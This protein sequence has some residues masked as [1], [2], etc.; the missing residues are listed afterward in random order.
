MSKIAVLLV[1]IGSPE[2]PQ[3]KDVGQYLRRFLM[4]PRVIEL[5]FVW[6]W[7]LVNL[8]IVP[9]RS[10]A[11]ARKYQEIWDRTR[12]RSPLMVNSEAFQKALGIELSESFQ[13]EV[14]M[15][16]SEPSIGKALMK[17][18]EQDCEGRRLLLVV[19]MFP[20]YARATTESVIQDVQQELALRKLEFPQGV[21]FLHSFY[22]QAG[23]CQTLASHAQQFLANKAVDHYLFSFHGLPERQILQ[24]PQCR[25]T[26]DCCAT[27]DP[28]KC[29]CYRAQC[30]QTAELLAEKMD[31]TPQQW[32]VSFQSRLGRAKWLGPDTTS[33]VQSLAQKGVRRL[34]ILSPAFVAD[35]LETLEEIGIGETKNFLAHGGQELILVP[36]LNSDPAWVKS[37]AAYLR[38]RI[39]S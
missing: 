17:F 5:P 31:L 25:L 14:A 4:D 30:L 10:R 24:D 13:V 16:F 6:R 28:V 26:A 15:S 19:P 12:N 9:R 20:Q 37:F 27:R 34:V 35:C 3:P 21:R 11:S 2:S 23:F 33:V 29:K 18:R 32:S 38:A 22:Q 1:N 36:A 7:L 39:D 8:L